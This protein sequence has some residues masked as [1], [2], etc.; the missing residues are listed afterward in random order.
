MR[1]DEIKETLRLHS[2]WMIGDASGVKANLSWANLSGAD[3][4]WA[5]LRWADLR[6]A[7]LSGA[8]LRWANLSRADLSWANL[9][10]AD[11]SWA[12]LREAN[13]SEAHLPIGIRII[14]VS[15]VGSARRMTTYRVDTDEAWCGCF[16]GTLSEFSAK[17]EETHKDNAV[18]LSDYR[19]VAA[20]FEAYKKGGGA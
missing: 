3:L 13:L 11:L 16:K 7:N 20:M 14:S 19:A 10:G 18:H 4:R 5:D 1:I 8:D 12:N 2:L 9:S 6:W 17:I 15:G